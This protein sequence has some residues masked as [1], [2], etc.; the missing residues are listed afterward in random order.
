[1]SELIPT[2]WKYANIGILCT[3]I[4]GRAFKPAEWSKNGLPII[5]IQNLNNSL[6]EFNYF[7]GKLDD[8][9][10]VKKGDLLF[11]WSGTP[12]T[13]FGA[14]IWNNSDG[15]LNQH[16][17]K[18]ELNEKYVN[19]KYLKYAINYK[20]EELI[21]KAHGGVGLRHVTK[22]KFEQTEIPLPPLAEQ[23]E[24]ADRLDKLLAQVG[25][26]KL[27]LDKIEEII[28]SFRQSVL[29]V[30]CRGMLTNDWRNAKNAPAWKT[31]LLK[32]IAEIKGGITK[33]IKKQKNS[34]IDIPY[35]RVANVQ[36]GYIDLTEVKTIK[37]PKEKLNE[38]LLEK[39]DILLNEGGDIDKLGRGWIWEGQIEPCSY[40]NHVFR[41]RLFN[42]ENE[43]K[44]I[45]WFANTIGFNFF[46]SSGKQTTGIASINKTMISNLEIQ[47]PSPSEQK[48][49]VKR[50]EELFFFISIIVQRVQAAKVRIDHLSQS[51]LIKAF[52]GELTAE[53]REQHPELI[54]GENSAVALLE[55][56]KEEKNSVKNS[57]RPLKSAKNVKIA[58]K[59][60]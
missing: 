52:S 48:E 59:R 19:K 40:Q 17:F 29:E 8:K 31:V 15:A 38:F 37:I 23:K 54:S 4:N 55:R 39:G 50:I 46:L 10:L 56:I 3:L 20:L 32:E 11:A 51:I 42:K 33:D 43:P 28:K 9:H 16:I 6:A 21:S 22:G 47:L 45:S 58:L 44:Y 49:I 41:A 35:L 13:S 30:A 7:D 5:R 27:R 60:K 26:I 1:M 24:I 53:W 12:G 34:D 36:R 2:Q 18:V 14:H 57:V 25:S